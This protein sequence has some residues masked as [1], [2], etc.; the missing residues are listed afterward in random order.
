MNGL[1]L[2]LRSTQQI[3]TIILGRKTC[4]KKQKRMNDKKEKRKRKGEC[5]GGRPISTKLG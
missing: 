5:V 3:S 4:V 2:A 1:I